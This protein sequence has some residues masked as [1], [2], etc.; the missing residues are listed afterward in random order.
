M[1][2]IDPYE[3]ID[4]IHNRGLYATEAFLIY[5]AIPQ[6]RINVIDFSDKRAISLL[7]GIPEDETFRLLLG[8]TSAGAR[9]IL[10]AYNSL[11]S[12]LTNPK[13]TKINGDTARKALENLMNQAHFETFNHPLTAPENQ[14]SVRALNL[15]SKDQHLE[16]H[17]HLGTELLTLLRAEKTRRKESKLQTYNTLPGPKQ[18]PPS[19]NIHPYNSRDNAE[20]LRSSQIGTLRRTTLSPISPKK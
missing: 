6:D 13:L 18:E 14:L 7:Q 12:A 4:Q 10:P 2:K 17:I 1:I 19:L 5:M 9:L 15:Y 8:E 11:V 20:L 3:I 16:A